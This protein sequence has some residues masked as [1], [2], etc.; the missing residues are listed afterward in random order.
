MQAARIADDLMKRVDPLEAA[1]LVA[2]VDDPCLIVL[3]R[4]VWALIALMRMGLV[5]NRLPTPLGR[6]VAMVLRARHG[7]EAGPQV[8]G[9]SH[10]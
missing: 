1:I 2:L 6:Q 5:A 8:V 3:P 9:S 10:V 7:V 4:D